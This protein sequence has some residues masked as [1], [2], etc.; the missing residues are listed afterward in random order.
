MK[1]LMVF[2]FAASL[3]A[4]EIPAA[5]ASSH[6]GQN[7]TVCGLVTG[8]HTAA[9]SKGKPTFLNFD[10]PYPSQDFTVMIWDDDRPAFGDLA[11]Y[12]GHRVC[13]HGTIKEFRG[14]PE[15]VLRDPAALEQ[16]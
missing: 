12:S 10:K 7:A 16:R 13:A 4:Q 8:V 15:M 14:K 11:K 2:A 3:S 9:G 1:A 5:E 6:A